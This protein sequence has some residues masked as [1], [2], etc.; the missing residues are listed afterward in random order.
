MPEPLKN[1]VGDQVVEELAERF[2]TATGLDTGAFARAL[3]AE[4]PALELKPRIEAIARRI[5]H[6]LPDDYPAA[7]QRVVQVAKQDPPI[8]G[9]AAWPLCTYVE[10]FGLAHPEESLAAMEHLT[11]RASC[12]FAVRPYLREHWELAYAKLEEF[13]RHPCADVRRLASEGMRPRLPW[14]ASVARLGSDFGPGLAL[15]ER[16][17]HDE[18]ETV[19]RSVANHL[20]D[21]SKSSPELAVATVER[22]SAEPKTDQRM[23]RHA[24]RTLVKQG[25]PGALQALGYDSQAAVTVDHFSVSPA[26]VAMGDH[27]TLEARITS[28][29]TRS[30]RLVVDF[31]IHH[32]TKSGQP[33]P[34]TFK[35][36]TLELEAGESVTLTKRR[37]IQMA[38]TRTYYAGTHLVQLQIAGELVAASSFDVTV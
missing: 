38:T 11:K 28:T 21:V 29:G 8:E 26:Q 1:M 3:K 5:D 13:T 12:E 25:H 17:R 9:F 7:L 33:S 10:I 35:W 14:G 15:L 30:Q 24:L 34:K 23:L 31:I 19:R 22:W 4:L 2:S 27:I 20:N 16:L 6:L 36:K 32:I 18:S 37:L